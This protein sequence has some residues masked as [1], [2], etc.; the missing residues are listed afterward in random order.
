MVYFGKSICHV[1][2]QNVIETLIILAE[3]IR[4]IYTMIRF[5]ATVIF[6]SNP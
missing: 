6:A 4:I 2:I 5:Y 1:Q 3:T